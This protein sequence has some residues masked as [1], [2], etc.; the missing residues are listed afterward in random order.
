M[1][2]LKG[3]M[4]I[5]TKNAEKKPDDNLYRDMTPD[6]FK[7]VM[8]RFFKQVSATGILTSE[9]RKA[10]LAKVMESAGVLPDVAARVLAGETHLWGP[11]ADILNEDKWQTWDQLKEVLNNNMYEMVD[12]TEKKE[13][14]KLYK[15]MTA[16]EYKDVIGGIFKELDFSEDDTLTV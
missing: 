8:E 6:A 5:I 3:N 1:D 14:A 11:A 9:D 7:E 10:F 13:E 2:V 4:H 16:G 15:N 12:G